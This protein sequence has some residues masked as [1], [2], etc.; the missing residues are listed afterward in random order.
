MSVAFT[1]TATY[2]SD[3]TREAV[4]DSGAADEEG[5]VSDLTMTEL[6][7]GLCRTLLTRIETSYRAAR[8]LV[9]IQIAKV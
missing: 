2:D 7:C 4:S 1:R 6:D 9:L 8:M 3:G 5:T